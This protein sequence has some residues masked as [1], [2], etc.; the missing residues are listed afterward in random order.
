MA[1][2]KGKWYPLYVPEWYH[3]KVSQ[4]MFDPYSFTHILHGFFFYVVFSWI[5]TTFLGYTSLD[6]LSGG[7][8]L[9]FAAE[10]VHEFGENSDYVINM[11]RRASGTSMFYTGDSVQNIVGDLIAC[12]F[13]YFLAAEFWAIGVWWVVPVW[14]VISEV[15]LLLYMRDSLLL[16]IFQ[17]AF[18]IE[19]I[20]DWQAELIPAEGKIGK[21]GEEQQAEFVQFSSMKNKLSGTDNDE[22]AD[23]ELNWMQESEFARLREFLAAALQ[24][25]KPENFPSRSRRRTSNF[26]H[27]HLESSDQLTMMHSFKH[28]HSNMI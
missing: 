7:A 5:P 3:P 17:L 21:V 25:F 28:S 22:I 14:S 6:A 8:V 15:A 10:L 2:H 4:F 18:E 27:N 11:Y 23:S 12:M 1:W 24:V 26:S 16:I 20:K 9:T 19:W 13:G